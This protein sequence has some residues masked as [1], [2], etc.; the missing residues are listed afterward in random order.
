MLQVNPMNRITI[1][2]IRENAWFQK[3][4][5]EYLNAA[6][7]FAEAIDPNRAIIPEALG[8]PEVHKTVIGRLGTTLG[9]AFDDVQEALLADEP[10]AIKDAYLIVRERQEQEKNLP[11]DQHRSFMQGTPPATRIS[12]VRSPGGHVITPDLTRHA[13][14]GSASLMEGRAP[15]STVAILPSSLPDYHAAYMKGHI[16]RSQVPTIVEDDEPGRPRSEEEKARRRSLLTPHSKST[17][18]LRNSG[19][20]DSMTTMQQEKEK[21]AKKRKGQKWQFG[22]R[23]RNSPAEAMLAI[24]KALRRMGAEWQVPTI[25][26]PG[27]RSGE[28]SPERRPEER[29]PSN[30]PEY[31]DSDPGPGSDP[32]YATHEEQERRRAERRR[33]Q[34]GSGGGGARG[35]D[36]HGRWND[37]GYE[38]PEDPW[39]IHARFRKSGMLPVGAPHPTS[40]H[41]SQVNLHDPKN[42]PSH[43]AFTPSQ[44]ADAAPTPSAPTDQTPDPD[45]A[46]ASAAEST[47]AF[48]NPESCWL[49]VTIQLYSIE[50]GVYLVDFK[51]A[52]Y[53]RLVRRFAHV[54]AAES[55][56]HVTSTPSIS[57][58]GGGVSALS[59]M[60]DLDRANPATNVSSSSPSSAPQPSSGPPGEMFIDSEGR[61][62][63]GAGRTSDEKDITSPYPFL[64]LASRLIIQLAEAND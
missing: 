6:P 60:I 40:A 29:E 26:D 46:Y 56:T 11:S 62:F 36:R 24:Y 57:E 41:S 12:S 1:Q 9:Y 20:P 55:G 13:S 14:T 50:S 28:G 21:S 4:L 31:S 19:K 2:G 47:P 49:Y 18:N 51:C 45:S 37:Y 35:R 10:S 48:A 25:R 52:G 3:N 16:D 30:S 17:A 22:I 27:I 53:E 63:V 32:E 43:L 59:N 44:P 58:G 39:V 64:D 8:D 38:I 34:L 54:V 15:V 42:I 33:N 61:E 5:P 23:S 7:E